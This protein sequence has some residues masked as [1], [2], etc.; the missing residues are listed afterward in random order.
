MIVREMP[1]VGT[2]ERTDASR[3]SRP[4][5]ARSRISAAV[6]VFETLATGKAVSSVTFRLAATSARPAAP[7]QMEPSANRIEAEMPGIPY[8]ARRRSRRALEGGSQER[9]RAG[10]AVPRGGGRD[11]RTVDARGGGGRPGDG[12]GSGRGCGWPCR[13]GTSGGRTDPHRMHAG[14]VRH[15]RRP[16]RAS[17]RARPGRAGAAINGAPTHAPT[18]TTATTRA[19]NGRRSPLFMSDGGAT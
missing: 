1:S 19:M 12:R 14:W 13:C 4:S 10:R 6:N 18:T 17:Q 15:L 9:R 8:F 7:R 2:Y 11:D 3:S 16:R 5:S